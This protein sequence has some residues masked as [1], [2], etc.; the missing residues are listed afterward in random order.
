MSTKKDQATWAVERIE[1]I[2]RYISII[3]EIAS[4]LVNI[5]RFKPE[6]GNVRS[7]LFELETTEW[8]NVAMWGITLD[9]EDRERL[10]AAI[11]DRH[12]SDGHSVAT[13]LHPSGVMPSSWMNAE[14]EAFR[15]M[16]KK[17]FLGD[18]VKK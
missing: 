10:S 16:V 7:L 5:H 15:E 17:A 2:Q 12:F 9:K 11:Y 14:E 18:F 8:R 1:K 6:F 4:F 13:W 3:D